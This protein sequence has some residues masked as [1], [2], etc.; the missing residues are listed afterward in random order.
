MAV[1]LDGQEGLWGFTRK[2]AHICNIF[3]TFIVKKA[4]FYKLGCFLI[5]LY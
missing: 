1:L 5:N 3:T 4:E 2:N